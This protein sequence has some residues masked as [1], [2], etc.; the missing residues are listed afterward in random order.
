MY[1][2]IVGIA[3]LLVVTD[4]GCN[5]TSPKLPVTAVAPSK[6]RAETT[7]DVFFKKPDLSKVPAEYRD[8]VANTPLDVTAGSRGSLPSDFVDLAPGATLCGSN[9]KLET[10]YYIS[11]MSDDELFNFFTEKLRARGCETNGVQ[12]GQ[13]GLEFLHYLPFSCKDGNGL[14]YPYSDRYAYSINFR[15]PR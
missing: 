13:P 12:Q 3:A 14:M 11:K 8:L 5:Q 2:K 10:S 6:V 4:A 1:K 15:K 9:L 7:C